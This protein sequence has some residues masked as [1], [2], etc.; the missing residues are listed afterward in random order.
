MTHH[1]SD[2]VPFIRTIR[3]L[4]PLT[5][6]VLGPASRRAPTRAPG[7]TANVEKGTSLKCRIT[8]AASITLLT[9]ITNVSL[10]ESYSVGLQ[11]GAFHCIANHLNTGSNTLKE[12]IPVAPQ[13]STFAKWDP[14]L[15]TF[16]ESSHYSRSGWSLNPGFAPGEAGLFFNNAAVPFTLTFTGTIPTPSLP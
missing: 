11:A 9:V 15:N 10:A 16:G 8:V 4:G 1:L 5:A 3:T 7:L 6:L 2:Y 13:G 12:V 14:L